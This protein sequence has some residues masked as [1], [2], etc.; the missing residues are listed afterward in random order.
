MDAIKLKCKKMAKH[1]L[2][3]QEESHNIIVE[4]LIKG[5]RTEGRSC[6]SFIFKNRQH[7]SPVIRNY[8][9]V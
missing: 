8:H 6:N 9:G 1:A 7:A 2:R 4:S 3:C 5:S